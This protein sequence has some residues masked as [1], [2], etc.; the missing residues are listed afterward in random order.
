M[1]DDPNVYQALRLSPEFRQARCTND[2]EGTTQ[3]MNIIEPSGSYVPSM[4]SLVESREV[5]FLTFQLTVDRALLLENSKVNFLSAIVTNLQDLY[6][7]LIIAVHELTSEIPSEALVPQAIEESKVSEVVAAKSH[8]K[9]SK[10]FNKFKKSIQRGLQ[11]RKKLDLT[12]IEDE[13]PDRSDSKSSFS[14]TA[15]T[16]QDSV[17]TIRKIIEQCQDI[18]SLHD[19]TVLLIHGEMRMRVFHFLHYIKDN[20]Y[21]R[22]DELMDS[23]WFIGQLSRELMQAYLSMKNILDDKKLYYIWHDVF[24][25][26]NDMFITGVG[27]VKGAAFSRQGLAVYTKNI[28][29]LQNE[30]SQFDLVISK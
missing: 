13:S 21:W 19:K 16:L 5:G 23:E 6:D 24:D 4:K 10:M 25:L 9:T 1:L 27:I 3:L 18:Q 14:I 11:G 26:I 17:S 2:F 12:A 28:R 15:S 22:E 29:V 8:P 7:E 20:N 30:L